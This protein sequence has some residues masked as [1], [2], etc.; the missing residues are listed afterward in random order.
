MGSENWRR[1]S[2]AWRQHRQPDAAGYEEDSRGSQ[3]AT[4]AYTDDLD[5]EG[6][7]IRLEREDE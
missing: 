2:A 3:T 1:S 5:A 7:L 6:D 4:V